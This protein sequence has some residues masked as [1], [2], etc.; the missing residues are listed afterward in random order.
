MLYRCARPYCRGTF[1]IDEIDGIRELV[2]LLCG[3]R[4]DTS[5]HSFPQPAIDALRRR[6]GH[7]VSQ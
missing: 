1:L 7:R 5:G 6:Q 4:A 2:C 3:R